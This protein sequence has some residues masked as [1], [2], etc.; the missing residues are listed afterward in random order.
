MRYSGLLPPR[1]G[2]MTAQ[3]FCTF[4]SLEYT[5]IK[6]ECENPSSAMLVNAGIYFIEFRKLQYFECIFEKNKHHGRFQSPFSSISIMPFLI[7]NFPLS[8]YQRKY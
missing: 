3:I 8:G 4:L 2:R 6:G 5:Q 7:N 1:F